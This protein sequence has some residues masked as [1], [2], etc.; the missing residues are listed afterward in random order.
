DAGD[1]TL[2]FKKDVDF[3]HVQAKNDNALVALWK[4]TRR[5]DGRGCMEAVEHIEKILAKAFTGKKLAQLGSVL[6]TDRE[7]L[8]LE[9]EE[10][11]KAGV[12]SASASA[13]DKIAIMQR[14]GVLGMN[15]ILSMS[16]ALG[17]A[18][19]ARDGKELWQLIREMAAETMAKFVAANAKSGKDLATLKRMGFEELQ[20][21]FRKTAQAAIKEQRTIYE[22]L[23]EQLKVYPV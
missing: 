16:L 3:A 10:A 22:L 11:V 5:Y 15:A 1:G 7:L 23:R 13:D 18:I 9:Y 19:A 2:R 14:K 17:R 21:E 8:K 12:I 4:K 20:T 6:E